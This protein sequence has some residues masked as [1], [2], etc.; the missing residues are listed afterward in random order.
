MERGRR[1]HDCSRTIGG[2][3]VSD[4]HLIAI[5]RV[6]LAE[7]G[8]ETRS[9]VPFLVEDWDDN[10]DEREIVDVSVGHRGCYGAIA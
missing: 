2:A 1:L 10:A 8:I 4:D 3:A 7:D 5:G 6:V 9:D